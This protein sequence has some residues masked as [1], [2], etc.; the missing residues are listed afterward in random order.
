MD[1]CQK[2]EVAKHSQRSLLTRLKLVW[3]SA[4]TLLLICRAATLDHQV[5]AVEV[6]L[7][8]DVYD[9]T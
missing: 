9:E 3:N 4:V 8:E 6:E 1:A 7:Q 2:V 5:T